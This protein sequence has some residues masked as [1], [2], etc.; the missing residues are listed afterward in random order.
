LFNLNSIM[1]IKNFKSFNLMIII[2]DCVVKQN[3][4]HYY[5]LDYFHFQI[6]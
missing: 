2:I 1:M 3:C 5:Y 4:L 6:H